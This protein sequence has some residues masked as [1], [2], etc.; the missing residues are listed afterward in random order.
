[1]QLPIRFDF[2]VF[3]FLFSLYFFFRFR[4][5]NADWNQF[6]SVVMSEKQTFCVRKYGRQ[7]IS[8]YKVFKTL[9]CN[10]TIK[11]LFDCTHVYLSAYTN[12]FGCYT[13][14]FRAMFYTEIIF[15]GVHSEKCLKWW[16][17]GRKKLQFQVID[18]E[19]VSR[20]EQVLVETFY[21]FFCCSLSNLYKY[22][23]VMPLPHGMDT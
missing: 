4:Y 5:W 13:C 12:I 21:V 16:K 20:N 18:I 19:S 8:L 15:R 14:S 9:N 1:M 11:I 17:K 22:L 6:Y 7:R 23:F 3:N 2:F 10:K